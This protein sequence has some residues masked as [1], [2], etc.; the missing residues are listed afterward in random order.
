[1]SIRKILGC[2]IAA[3]VIAMP[4]VILYYALEVCSARRY[5]VD[6]ILPRVKAAH[7]P[8]ELSSLTSRQLEILLKVEAPR[9][10]EP[11]IAKTGKRW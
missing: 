4:A 10:F 3:G 9:F 5:T 2:A 8:L 7:Y 1:V 11:A 6:T